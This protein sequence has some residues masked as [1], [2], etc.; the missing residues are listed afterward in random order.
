MN[1]QITNTNRLRTQTKTISN[2][3]PTKK[4]HKSEQKQNQLTNTN[5]IGK[6]NG[7]GKF[8]YSSGDRFEG[9]VVDGLR[10]GEGKLFFSV[11]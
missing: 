9:S 2:K 7:T 11:K 1:T 10:H 3:L 6:P 8:F 5:K 4:H